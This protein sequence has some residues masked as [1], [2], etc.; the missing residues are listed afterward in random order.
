MAGPDIKFPPPLLFLAAV[1]LGWLADRAAP[2]FP[3]PAGSWLLGWPFFLAGLLLDGWAIWR[4]RHHRTTVLP[5]APA[6]ARVTDG[7]FRFSRNP[8]Y[9]GYALEAAGLCFAL[10]T[11]WGWIF[12]LVVLVVMDRLVVPREERHLAEAFGETYEAYRRRVRRW[13]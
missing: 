4:L 8:I 3:P 12:L 6:S 9:L 1:G 13:L 5:W 2:V 11:L 7:P 10:G